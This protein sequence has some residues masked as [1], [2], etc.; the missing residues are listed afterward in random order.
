MQVECLG[1]RASGEG[2]WAGE[3]V[4]LKRAQVS[5]HSDFQSFKALSLSVILRVFALGHG[6]EF[7]V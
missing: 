4:W 1:F 6:L 7:R 2:F 5:G 3:R